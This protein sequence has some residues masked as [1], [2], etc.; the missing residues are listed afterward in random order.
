MHDDS[1]A[2]AR[3]LVEDLFPAARWA[4]LTGSVLTAA[5]TPGSDLDI[6]VF[7]DAGD[8]LPFRD[9]LDARHDP[10]TLLAMAAELIASTGGPLVE[11]FRVAG[12]R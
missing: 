4:M 11:G 10:R 9:W 5:R 6:L 3:R 1:V 12:E 8:G 7:L 2:A